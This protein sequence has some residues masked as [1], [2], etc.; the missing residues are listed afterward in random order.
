M[1][2]P[3]YPRVVAAR[4]YVRRLQA[5]L[6]KGRWAASEEGKLLELIGKHGVGES[7]ACCPE[8]LGAR[9]V[10]TPAPPVPGIS[11]AWGSGSSA[12]CADAWSEGKVRERLGSTPPLETAAPGR[13]RLPDPLWARFWGSFIKLRHSM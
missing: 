8:P 5:G 1:W 6:K 7:W 10:A 12:L 3:K 13:T 11:P 9:L 2:R 4:R